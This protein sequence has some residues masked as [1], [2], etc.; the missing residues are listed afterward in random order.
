[1]CNT[2]AIDV[3]CRLL[4]HLTLDSG[5]D[6]R[7]PPAAALLLRS[8]EAEPAGLS[9]AIQSA[10]VWLEILQRLLFSAPSAYLHPMG[11][12]TLARDM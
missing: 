6:H 4:A 11:K 7:A 1:M 12:R 3:E 9:Q 2:L 10:F 8:I 5:L